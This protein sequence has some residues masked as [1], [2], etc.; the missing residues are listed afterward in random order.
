MGRGSDA[1]AVCFME[2]AADG[3]P[4]DVYGVGM[5][6]NIVTASIHA[7]ISAINRIWA[8]LPADRREALFRA[9]EHLG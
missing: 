5:H 9:G 6:P 3:V 7:V 8:R 1:R 4:G 2:L